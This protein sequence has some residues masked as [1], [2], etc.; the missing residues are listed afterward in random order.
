M[1]APASAPNG[2]LAVLRQPAFLA[3]EVS[4]LF[5]G[6]AFT[7]LRAAVAWQVY[8]TS[9]SAFHLGM[10]GLL[11]FLPALVLNLVGG[12]A[13]DAY[14]RKRL[15]MLFQVVPALCS[16][17]LAV[18]SREQAAS[19][20]V[21]YAVV[22]LV[23]AAAA[24]ES[25]ARSALL[26]QLVERRLFPTA[27]NV[28]SAIQMGAF[29]TGPVVMGFAVD[30]GGVALAYGLHAA[31]MAVGLAS[32]TL[33][34]P[35]HGTAPRGRVHWSAI[36]EGLRYVRRQPVVLGC[37]TLDMFAVLF[38]GATALLPIYATDILDVGPRGYGL[39]AS[40]LE[41]GAV[42][43]AVAMLVLPPVRRTGLALLW[44]VVGFAASTIVFGLSRHY[45]LSLAAYMVAGVSDYLSVVMRGVAIQLSTPDELRG[46]VSAVNLI[47]I[48]ASNQLGAAESG[49][50]AALTSPTFSVVSGGAGALVV[51]ILV[52]WLNPALRRYRAHQPE[53]TH[54]KQGDP[55]PA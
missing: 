38:G 1:P 44:A 11:Q 24:F 39:L 23:A 29:V 31:L 40:S 33:V 34:R 10:V 25:P 48:G 18:A 36:A 12:A 47:F 53:T 28:H 9:G 52:A 22:M 35:L 15:V 16:T 20:G 2:A 30:R 55:A 4:R 8:E 49:F 27:V 21:L 41:I 54:A 46:R 3:F 43:A 6:T 42:A 17:G 19:L 13:A 26:P 37:M 7:L 51:A 32:I 45:P 50:V 14:D 5:S